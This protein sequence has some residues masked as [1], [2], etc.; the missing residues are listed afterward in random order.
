[1]DESIWQRQKAAALA[2]AEAE[3]KEPY[4]MLNFDPSPG[5]V[6]AAHDAPLDGV[7]I[8]SPSGVE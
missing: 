7:G 3:G 5:D 4:E 8:D 1:M 2:K 6:V